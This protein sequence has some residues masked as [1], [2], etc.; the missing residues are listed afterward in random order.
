M[1]YQYA[2]GDLLENRNTYFYSRFGGPA[3]LDQWEAA[4]AEVLAKLPPPHEARSQKVSAPTWGECFDT[5]HLLEYLA[6]A[7][8]DEARRWLDKLIQRFEVTKRVHASYNERLRAMDS[9]DYRRLELYVRFAEV[10]VQAGRDH[11][12]LPAINALLK[13]IDTLCAY[14]EEIHPTWQARLSYVIEEER[15]LIRHL[16]ER[17]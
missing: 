6:G 16:E 11:G 14:A 3:F 1:K 4:R 10:L 9:G 15:K 17:S 2:S 7:G 13:V 5:A 8:W 12:Y